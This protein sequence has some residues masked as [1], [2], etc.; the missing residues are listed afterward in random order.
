M[1]EREPS[2]NY[3]Q[4]RISRRRG[5][6]GAALAGAGLA[7]AAL[8]ACTN[9][10]QT[11]TTGTQQQGAQPKRGGT[12]T[13][14]RGELIDGYGSGFDPYVLTGAYPPL[15]GLFYQN[16][17]KYHGVT[18]DLSPELAQ[19]WEQVSPTEYLLTLSPGAKWQ[20]KP[21]ANGRALTAA[22][23]VYS[24]NR[25][26]SE[27]PKFVNRSLL[28][29]AD[30]IEAVDQSH[31]RI[32]TKAPDASFLFNLADVTM[33][34]LNPEVVERAG[35]FVEPE[36]AVGTGAFILQSS[37]DTGSVLV[38]N[39]DYWKP[40]LPYLDSIR[41][42]NLRDPQARFAAFQ[43]GQFDVV[44]VPGSE[45]K[46]ILGDRSGK[47]WTEWAKEVAV[48]T[49]WQNTRRKPFDDKR[50][51]RAL[52]LL[53]DHTEAITGWAEVWFGKGYL[54]G[55]A[56]LPTILDAWDYSEEEYRQAATP[57]FLEWK[58]PKDE[59][60]REAISLLSAAGITPDNPLRFELSAS[61]SPS[62]QAGLQLQQSQFNRLSRGAVQVEIRAMESIQHLGLMTRGEF[63]VVGPIMRGGYIE[64]DI[65]LQQVYKSTGGQ[66]F[67][68]YTDPA[69]DQMIDRQRTIF[70]VPQR[71]AAIK[72][73]NTYLIQNAP[74]TASAGGGY[75]NATK[76][77]VKGFI[78]EHNS[79]FRGDPYEQLW[80]D[81]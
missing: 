5:L 63:D 21:P 69:L 27:D 54:T 38:R 1:T 3:W 33:V 23:I 52:R 6:Q 34:I 2:G 12:L 11:G 4:R 36:T 68:K 55:S 81:V 77:A 46:N 51:N 16:L 43:A 10:Q 9:E 30:K 50:V 14:S 40:G 35:R 28:N 76:S 26:R 39:P 22:D 62:S 65:M 56:H 78:P 79:R 72:E 17:I 7:A 57:L 59:A 75:L 13:R 18:L 32:T 19:K 74:Y 8:I 73:I 15:M 29:S 60:A 49:I 37:D 42:I 61:N 70:D 25:F 80:L 58:Q 41:L 66:N 31:V 67:G 45:A 44:Q 71:K 20:N 48:S 64:P 53:V 24:L 47:Y